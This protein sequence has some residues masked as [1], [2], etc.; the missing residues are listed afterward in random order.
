MIIEQARV[1][2]VEGERVWVECTTRTACEHCQAAKNCGTS[3]ISKALPKRTQQLMVQSS[4]EVEP[5]QVVEIGIPEDSLVRSALVVYLWPLLGM[6]VGAML[7]QQLWPS[8]ELA[9]IGCSVAGGV[10]GALLAK[11]WSARQVQGRAL[12]PQ[13]LRVL[14]AQPEVKITLVE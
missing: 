12:Q 9:V 6:V 13:V 4:L 8:V 5:G 7:G 1:S 14:P 10:L 2:R 11:R 3:A